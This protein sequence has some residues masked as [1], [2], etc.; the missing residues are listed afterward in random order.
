MI[1]LY[2]II[3]MFSLF[4]IISTEIR[5]SDLLYNFYSRTHNENIGITIIT[6][7]KTINRTNRFFEIFYIR[8]YFRG[9][10]MFVVVF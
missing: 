6:D 2:L 10:V 9:Y 4:K 5:Y 8:G 3:F 7:S 1:L